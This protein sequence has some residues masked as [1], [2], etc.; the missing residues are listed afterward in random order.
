MTLPINPYYPRSFTVLVLV[1][2]GVLILPLASGL[3]RTVHLLQSSIETQRQF[4]RDSLTITRDI[5]QIVDGVSQWQRAAGQYHLLLDAELAASVRD[6]YSDLHSR[7]IGLNQLLPTPMPRAALQAVMTQSANLNHRLKPGHFLDSKAFNA[8]KPDFDALHAEAQSLQTRGDHF[9]HAQ[10]RVLEEE[11]Q[12]TRQRLILLTVALIPLTLLLAGVFSW[13]INRPIRQLKDAIQ[14]LARG[15]LSALPRISGPQ[16]IVALRQE[17]EWLRQRLGEIEEQKAQFL[18]HVSHELKTP[19]ASLREGV[20]LLAERLTG[21]MT[22]RQQTIVQIMDHSSRE[23]QQRIEDLIRY[24]GMVREVS[25]PPL[26]PLLL[27][28]VFDTVVTRHRLAIETRSITIDAQWDAPTVYADQDRMETVLDNLLSNAI[29]FSP[30]NGCILIRSKS[31][32]DTYCL[33]ICDQGPGITATDR[34]RIFDAFVQGVTQPE[35]AVSGSGLGLSIVR[36]AMRSMG[37]TVTVIDLPSWSVCLNLE[38]RIPPPI[39]HEHDHAI[40]P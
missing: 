28:N 15:D 21:P 14:Q 19:L 25:T 13:M 6:S 3:I 23:L 37:G 12:A 40:N 10:L 17:I 16:D 4:T 24:S 11:M 33:Q 30:V 38:W 31:S 35:S 22:E 1:A 18:R 2:M 20:G 5:R 34:D 32:A 36:E 39:F 29:K 9:V 27:S 8:L 7:L 26:A